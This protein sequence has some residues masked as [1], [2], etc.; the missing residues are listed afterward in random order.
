MT[1]F[2]FFSLLSVASLRQLD[3]ASSAAFT[4]SCAL[5]ESPGTDAE[6]KRFLVSSVDLVTAISPLTHSEER[7]SKKFWTWLPHGA[8]GRYRS[9]DAI[10]APITR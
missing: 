7:P 4:A 10:D 1:R 6:S 8:A 5:P 3:M 2:M 9:P